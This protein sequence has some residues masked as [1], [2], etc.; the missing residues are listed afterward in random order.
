MQR[1]FAATTRPPARYMTSFSSRSVAANG[2]GPPM[3]DE[4]ATGCQKA[5]SAAQSV[6]V[7]VQL[8]G[9]ES[10]WTGAVV[11]MA[12][13][14]LGKPSRPCA[15]EGMTSRFPHAAGRGNIDPHDETRRV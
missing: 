15:T 5:A 4:K 6:G 7:K 11:R 13:G 8:R 3:S 14:C 9:K 1:S 12:G 2:L 10:V